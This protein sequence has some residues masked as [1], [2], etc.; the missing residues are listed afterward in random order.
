MQEAIMT[1]ILLPFFAIGLPH[2]RLSYWSLFSLRFPSPEAEFTNK[3]LTTL[4]A[5]IAESLARPTDLNDALNRKR[6]RPFGR[7]FRNKS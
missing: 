3:G 7:I 6:Q 2:Q 5:D 4:T 1:K